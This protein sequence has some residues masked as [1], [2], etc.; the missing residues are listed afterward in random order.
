MHASVLHVLSARPTR[1]ANAD[2]GVIVSQLMDN[3]NEY[4]TRF[5]RKFIPNSTRQSSSMHKLELIEYSC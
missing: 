4:L 5:N 3:E 1:V 2:S